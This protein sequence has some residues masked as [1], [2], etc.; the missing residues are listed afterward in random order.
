[1]GPRPERGAAAVAL[2]TL[3]GTPFLY[4]GEELGLEDAVVAP[5]RQVDPGGRD[6]CRAPIPWTADPPHGWGPTPWLPFPPDVASRAVEAQDSDPTSV[7]HLYRRLLAARRASPALHEGDQEVLPTSG[8]VLGWR[9][10]TGDDER[11]VLIN[12]GPTP[13]RVEATG[14]SRCRA[15]ERAK[16]GPSRE[17]WPA[18]PPCS[19]LREADPGAGLEQQP[20]L[21]VDRQG[22]LAGRQRPDGLPHHVVAPPVGQATAVAHQQ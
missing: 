16:D 18:T 20:T 13:A 8:S 19:S 15:T 2:L 17:P 9:R 7:L 4:A 21:I 22:G 5:E 1:M 12:M 3:R 6:G 11:T 10:R 14:R